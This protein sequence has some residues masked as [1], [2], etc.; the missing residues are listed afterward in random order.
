AT[1]G[2]VSAN[3]RWAPRKTSHSA[4]STSHLMKFGGPS[5][6]AKSSRVVQETL[7]V[8]SDGVRT[9]TTL[10]QARSG[11]RDSSAGRNATDPVDDHTARWISRTFG[12]S[13]FSTFSF[14]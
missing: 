14:S 12:N 10:P 8:P 13:F 11:D 2:R 5:V 7:R 3:T 4:P 9:D 1:N 6:Q